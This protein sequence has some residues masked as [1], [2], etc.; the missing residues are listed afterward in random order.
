MS[1]QQLVYEFTPTTGRTSS[2]RFSLQ[3][4]E[5][6]QYVNVSRW[7]TPRKGPQKGKL[8]PGGGLTVELSQLSKLEVG[9]RAVR[10]ATRD[11]REEAPTE[12]AAAGEG[13]TNDVN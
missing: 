1:D 8:V 4:F 12:G 13:A 11:G 6:R 3:E 10:R 2:I 7:W 9:L 5:G